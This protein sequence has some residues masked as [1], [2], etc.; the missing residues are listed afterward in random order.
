MDPGEYVTIGEA[1]EFLGVSEGAVRKAILSD[2]LACTL[3]YGRKLISRSDLGEYKA[4]TQPNGEVSRGRPLGSK[5]VATV[6]GP[7]TEEKTE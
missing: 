7:V 2:R 6:S 4:R 5:K 1:A 3:L